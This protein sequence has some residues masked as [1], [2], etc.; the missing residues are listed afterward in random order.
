MGQAEWDD[1]EFPS[2]VPKYDEYGIDQGASSVVM[3]T[4][5]QF[6]GWP[7]RKMCATEHLWS[8]PT[9]SRASLSSL[10]GKTFRSCRRCH[11]YEVL[12]PAG[13]KP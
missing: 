1:P 8:E 9:V 3:L 4:I 11:L 10:Y 7:G 2:Y 5:D 12:E 13:A 6:P